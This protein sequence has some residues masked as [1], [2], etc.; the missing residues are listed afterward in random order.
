MS[1]SLLPVLRSDDPRKFKM[2]LEGV[3]KL[4]TVKV[5]DISKP[6][7][8][9]VDQIDE[10]ENEDEANENKLNHS[11]ARML[12]L[13]L[14]DANNTEICALET[15]RIPDLDD[16]N[17]HWNLFIEGPVEIRCGKIMLEKKHITSKTKLSE[18]EIAQLPS[19]STMSPSLRQQRAPTP[20][21]EIQ[22]LSPKRDLSPL[23][24]DV[25][26][27]TAVGLTN[28]A[29]DWDDTD[30]EDCIIIE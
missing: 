5:L 10:P 30:D 11:N 29:E 18:S 23:A 13:H 3:Y 20:V 16:V 14:R 22:D 17:V 15:E 9:P 1:A 8:R 28:A 12:Q 26:P 27:R 21:I 7:A 2:L 24:G 25:R 6:T 19:L 4:R